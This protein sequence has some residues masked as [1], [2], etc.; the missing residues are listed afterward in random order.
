MIHIRVHLGKTQHN[1]I[2]ST[3]IKKL[4]FTSTA[5]AGF[6]LVTNFSLLLT[7]LISNV[8]FFL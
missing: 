6:F 1:H 4:N 5:E 7:T 3:Q 8:L 2:I